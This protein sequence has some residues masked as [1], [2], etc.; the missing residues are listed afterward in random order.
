MHYDFTVW[1]WGDAIAFDGLLEA[2]DLLGFDSAREFCLRYLKRWSVKPLT[3][4]DHLTPGRALVRAFNQTHDADLRTGITKL[5]H[6]L[7]EVVPRN[8]AGAPLFQPDQPAYRTNVWVDALY[9]VPPFLA[10]LGSEQADRFDEALFMWKTHVDAL[11]SEHGPFLAHSRDTGGRVLRGYGWGRGMGWALLG[12]VDTLE[13]LPAT[14]P[15]YVAAL[16]QFQKFSECVLEVQDR[17][18]FWRTLLHEREAY[19]E[20]STAAFF[21][22][23]FTK[24]LRLG[25]LQGA[26]YAD[27]TERAWGAMISRIDVEGSFFGVSACTWAGTAPD[28]DVSMYKALPTEVNVWGQ[29]SALRFAAERI[30]AKEGQRT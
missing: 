28:D 29:G 27:A 2:A 13:L 9:H 30:R 23:T 12:M 19:L 3:W 18:G 6:W 1:F 5:E 21:G 20:S 15:G 16:A 17:S 7:L 22:A 10:V 25:L 11:S 4:I 26:R 14:H 8:S 24:A